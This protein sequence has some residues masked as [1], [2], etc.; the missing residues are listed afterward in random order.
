VSLLEITGMPVFSHNGGSRAAPAHGL[1]ITIRG[2]PGAQ[3]PSWQG[4]LNFFVGS[5]PKTFPGLRVGGSLDG[6]GTVEPVRYRQE[7]L[8]L[9]A[10]RK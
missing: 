1:R 8:D 7:T 3:Q 4:I 2:M 9:A 6:H 5:M 10:Q